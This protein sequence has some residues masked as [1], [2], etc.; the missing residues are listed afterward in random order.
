MGAMIPNVYR[1][2]KALFNLMGIVA[3]LE[4]GTGGTVTP[5]TGRILVKSVEWTFFIYFFA[6]ATP[7]DV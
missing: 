4:L 6:V 5:L 1:M 7:N 2:G 3:K